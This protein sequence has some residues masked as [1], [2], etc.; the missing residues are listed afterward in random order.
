[1][2][3]K[4]TTLTFISLCASLLIGCADDP[5]AANSDDNTASGIIRQIAGTSAIGR[6]GRWSNNCVNEAC[7]RADA[8]GNY[9]IATDVATSALMWSDI[10][11]ADG[12]SIR[13]YSRYRLDDAITTSLVNINPSTDAILDIWARASQGQ[14]IDLCAS[15][16]VCASALMTSFTEAT[17][18]T[19]IDQLDEFIGDAWPAGR[20]PFDD[21]Y[22]VSSSDAL[23]VMHD[24]LQ[25]I[26]TDT[27]LQ[28][29][30]NNS[31]VLASTSIQNLTRDIS[32][33]NSALT[34]SQYNEA[35]AID[36]TIPSQ[37]SITLSATIDPSQP[38]NAPT[39]VTV[40]ASR[41]T[42]P[43]GDLTFSHDLS[44]TTGETIEFE[45][46]I[47]STSI[48][49]SGNQIWV[50][51]ATDING[52]TRTQGYVIQLLAD[53][54]SE[55]VFGGEGSCITPA[56]AMT[57]NIQNICEETQ[58]GSEL[59]QCDVLNSSSVTLSESP[60]PCAHEQQNGGDLLGICTMLANESRVF[61]YVNPLRLINIETFEDQQARV[62][63]Q[64]EDSFSGTW[65]TTP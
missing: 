13:L 24:H 32:L 39:T 4:L 34:L 62:G 14:S 3:K 45:G 20:N 48:E 59:G 41:S 65:S 51:T 60:A 25:F 31:E 26:V 38:T 29:I 54:N 58:N 18:R 17:E 61:H 2:N 43:I 6:A 50:V 33:T 21:V 1:M 10:P 19:I 9:L 44:L 40:D 57:A 37:N 27:E 49:V 42:S 36:P 63:K 16:S 47:V 30:D 55:P 56:S 8:N 15:D 12:S 5:A 64:C 35:R 52:H 7:A 46:D 53:D 22:I 11:E 28:V 23:D